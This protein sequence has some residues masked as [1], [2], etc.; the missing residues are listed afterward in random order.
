MSTGNIKK[1]ITLVN[2][3]TLSDRELI[4]LYKKA[5]ARGI[6]SLMSAIKKRMRN[7][8]PKAAGRFF[9]KKDAEAISLLEE[10]SKEILQTYSLK[11]NKLKNGVKTGGKKL[12]GKKYIDVYISY[13]NSMNN[14]VAL[15]LSQDGPD[16]ELIATYYFYKTGPGGFRKRKTFGMHDYSVAVS[17]F[18][19]KLSKL[20]ENE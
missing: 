18:K 8:F 5:E 16:S 6:S 12:S 9:G 3:G 2:G 10:L 20:L 4:S 7:Q 19:E 13:K 1:L 17:L 15:G 14:A 11:N